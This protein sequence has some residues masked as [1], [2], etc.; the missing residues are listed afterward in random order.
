MGY[1]AT[2]KH[3]HASWT[4]GT[5]CITA[6]PACICRCPQEMH[7]LPEARQDCYRICGILI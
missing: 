3:V 7:P 2:A 1:A 6:G 5:F 4:G